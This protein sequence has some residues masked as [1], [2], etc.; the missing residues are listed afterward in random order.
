[1]KLDPVTVAFQSAADPHV[2][3]NVSDGVGVQGR[4]GCN[5]RLRSKG[6]GGSGSCSVPSASRSKTS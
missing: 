3:A 1:M 4:R 2:R 6:C 5:G